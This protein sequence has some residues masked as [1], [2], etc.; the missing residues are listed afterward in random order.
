MGKAI[1]YTT[2]AFLELLVAGKERVKFVLEEA[3]K[4]SAFGSLIH[5]DG[6]IIEYDEDFC[7]VI[8]NN[9]STA[10][11]GMK[12]APDAKLNDGL[13]DLLLVRS[14]NTA[15]LINIFKKIYE[16]TH[17]DLPYVEYRQ[18]KSFSLTPYKNTRTGP[19]ELEELIDIDGELKG[20]TPFKCTVLPNAVRVIL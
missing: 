11:K 1:R 17:T 13:I 19:E 4:D 9:I 20:S 10:A 7:L 3:G 12:M 5:I 14:S 16:G 2:S 8:A 15:H 6:K 18:L